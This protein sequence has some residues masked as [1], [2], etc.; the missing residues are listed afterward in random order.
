MTDPALPFVTVVV[1]VYNESAF[2]KRCLADILGQDYPAERMEV[3]V[4]DGHSTD[5]TRC[6]VEA[7]AARDGR[8]RLLDNPKRI[9]AAAFNIGVRAARGKYVLR[10]DAHAGYDPT[11]MRRCVETLEETG[12]AN[13]GGKWE[14]R[15]SGKGLI[16]RAIALMGTLRFGVGGSRFRVGGKAGPVDLV[17]LGAFRRDIFET[18]GLMDERLVRGEDNELCGRIRRHGLVVYFQPEAKSVYYARRTVRGYMK[19]M[20]DN[21]LYHVLTLRVNPSGCSPRHLVPFAF[22]T[23]LVA[24]AVAGFFWRPAWLLGAGALGL[25]AAA[26]LIASLFAAARHGWP[27]LAVLPWL[28]FCGHT[29]Y[30]MGTWGGVMKFGFK[31][32]PLEKGTPQDG[33]G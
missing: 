21:G 20:Y 27:Y 17:G 10:M 13:V 11:Y 5:D 22:V 26:D 24:A 33:A 29:A 3:L 19:Q 16:A 6:K 7:V 1:P 2:I 23:G 32:T 9:Q 25:Y 30:G 28:F 8:V 12:A 15:P 4:V 18:V 14:T 31:R